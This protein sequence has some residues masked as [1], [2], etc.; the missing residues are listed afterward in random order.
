MKHCMWKVIKPEH[1]SVFDRRRDFG[2]IF[3]L[4][5]RNVEY[6]CIKESFFLVSLTL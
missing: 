1:R 5:V 4:E 6:P 2:H 3:V